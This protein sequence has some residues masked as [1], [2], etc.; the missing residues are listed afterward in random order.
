MAEVK[1]HPNHPKQPAMN[2]EGGFIW[3]GDEGTKRKAVPGVFVVEK[4]LT[5]TT[6]GE[7]MKEENVDP[8]I[9]AA[10]TLT[11]SSHSL[12]HH[13]TVS[14]GGLMLAIGGLLLN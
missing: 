13:F 10:G 7:P 11:S 2:S 8:D 3:P 14:M 9:P 4:Y 5:P 12:L 6:I 1:G